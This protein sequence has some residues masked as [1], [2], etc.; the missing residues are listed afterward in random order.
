MVVE[1]TTMISVWADTIDMVV[2]ITR[3]STTCLKK[4]R[5]IGATAPMFSP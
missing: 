5:A 3:K 2:E 4:R 1:S